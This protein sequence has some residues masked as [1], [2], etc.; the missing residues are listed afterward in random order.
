MRAARY[1]GVRDV[2]IEEVPEPEAGPGQVKVKVAHNGVCGSDLHEYFSATTF[3]PLEPHPLTKAVAPVILGHEF[4]GTIVAVGE[5]V[6]RVSVG[7]QAAIRPNY[8]CGTCAACRQGLPNVCRLLAFHGLS[9]PGGGL[10]D[11]T[12]VDED[13]VHVLPAGVSLEMGAL[14]EPMAVG[15]HAVARSSVR[16]GQT[17]VI[18]GLGPIGIGIWLALRAQGITDVVCSDPSPERRDALRRLGAEH[19][20][21]PRETD[22]AEVCAGLSD[23]AGAS[24][25]FDAAGTGAA[26][27]G[28]LPALAPRG[29]LVVVALHEK[30]TE[31]NPTSL[32]L[33]ET[34]LIGSLIYTADDYDR[35]IAA[36]AAGSYAIDGWVEHAG[37]DDLPEVFESLRAGQRMKVLIDL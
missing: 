34:A 24:V 18:A 10:S 21:D 25:A 36:M 12:V 11:F 2:R 15:H 27:T 20:V 13:A 22:L 26:I 9:G 23:G 4:S 31:F 19:V 30:P 14:V 8:H 29:T 7:D 32:V 1:H 33:Q 37:L 35:V 5:G 28:T 6:S 3:V 17:A 16:P